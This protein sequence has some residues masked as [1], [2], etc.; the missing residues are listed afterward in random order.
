[1]GR[2]RR[3]AATVAALVIAVTLPAAAHAPP[4]GPVT[5]KPVAGGTALSAQRPVLRF[6]G[7]MHNPTPLPT[8]SDP[9]PTV[10]AV[11]CQLWSL[12]VHTKRPFLVSLH[13]DN[14]SIDDGFNLYVYD[15]AGN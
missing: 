13:N 7:Q 15:P 12:T 2:S 11:Q 3:L 6:A 4:V 8:V 5:P 9:D 10:C 14:S 1:M